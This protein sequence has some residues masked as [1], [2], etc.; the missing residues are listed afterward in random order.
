MKRR[1]GVF[2]IRRATH[3]DSSSDR[4]RDHTTQFDMTAGD[5]VS[6][7]GVPEA[8]ILGVPVESHVPSENSGDMDVFEFGSQSDTETVDAV[9]E[10]ELADESPHVSDPDPVVVKSERVQFSGRRS[11]VWTQSKTVV[12]IHVAPQ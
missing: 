8:A 10:V 3:V 5:T 6:E 4:E 2:L 11:E 12:S 1:A 9:S 7:I